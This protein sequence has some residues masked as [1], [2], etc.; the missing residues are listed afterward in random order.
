[1]KKT[2]DH[3]ITTYKG[4]TIMVS[5]DY[6]GRSVYYI[7]ERDQLTFESVDETEDYIDLLT[8]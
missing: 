5:E 7:K 1:M 2:K 8:K 6:G 4:F 3:K